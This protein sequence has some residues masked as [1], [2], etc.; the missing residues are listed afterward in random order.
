MIQEIGWYIMQEI[1]WYMMVEIRHVTILAVDLHANARAERRR[2]VEKNDPPPPGPIKT[3]AQL[4]FERDHQT[5]VT[6][7]GD[8]YDK[9]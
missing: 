6:P 1:E 2:R 9:E 4:L 8:Y 7:G 5:I 3:A